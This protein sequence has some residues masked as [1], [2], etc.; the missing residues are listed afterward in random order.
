[1]KIFRNTQNND[2]FD[3]CWIWAVARIVEITI[4]ALSLYR[5]TPQKRKRKRIAMVCGLVFVV[6]VGSWAIFRLINGLDLI[7]L[8]QISD[9]LT[10]QEL[11]LNRFDWFG[12]MWFCVSLTR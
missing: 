11:G 7:V 5:F 9:K 2:V 4:P 10:L 6:Q 3:N 12:S 8:A 1:M